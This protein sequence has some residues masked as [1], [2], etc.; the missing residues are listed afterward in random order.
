MDNNNPFIKGLTKKPSKTGVCMEIE[1]GI[2]QSYITFDEVSCHTTRN[3]YDSVPVTTLFGNMAS[4]ISNDINIE[5]ISNYDERS[6]VMYME[7][8]KEIFK[9]RAEFVLENMFRNMKNDII[10]HG[11][12][13]VLDS[14]TMID[15]DLY[16]ATSMLYS[17]VKNKLTDIN[18]YLVLY[19][20]YEKNGIFENE[21]NEIITMEFAS[22]MISSLMICNESQLSVDNIKNIYSSVSGIIMEY[23]EMLRRIIISF[24][25][26]EPFVRLYIKLLV[27]Y[28]N[29]HGDVPTEL[30]F[31]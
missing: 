29:I 30:K 4:Y 27:C 11:K 31:D 8:L 10:V 17:D 20:N 23:A 19:L 18:T 14:E 9:N 1:R 28:S 3:Y 26:E 24:V 13:Y 25:M 7:S 15:A 2:G 21:M 6:F 12:G 5:Q 22:K 16:I